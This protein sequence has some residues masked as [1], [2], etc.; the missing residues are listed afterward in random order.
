MDFSTPATVNPVAQT[1]NGYIDF[2]GKRRRI[3]CAQEFELDA[4]PDYDAQI[5]ATIRAL[6]TLVGRWGALVRVNTDGTATVQRYCRL[7]W[8]GFMPKA[9]QRGV[10]NK[11]TMRFFS[12]EP[13]WRSQNTTTHGPTAISSGSGIGVTIAGEED[14]IDAVLT[15]AATGNIPTIT[16]THT[17]TENGLTVTSK[18]AKTS[19]LNNG[20]SWV[21]DTGLYT[22]KVGGVGDLA[23]FSLDSTH[24]EVF[25][26]R[27]PAG[28]NTFTITLGGGSG[29]WSLAYNAAYQ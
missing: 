23:N 17:K 5:A 21:V 1:I 13:F 27:F 26:L 7:L 14:V 15:I 8:V 6:K 28:S 22:A 10:V 18:F 25:W 16:V 3:D 2:Y 20:T 19:Q 11:L 9:T 4:M 12:L 24:D 29:T